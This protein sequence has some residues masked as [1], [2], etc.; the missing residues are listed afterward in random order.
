MTVI[1]FDKL[2]GVQRA[3]MCLADPDAPDCPVVAVND[4]FVDLTGYRREDIL[5]RNCRFL[6]GPG[7][8]PEAVAVLGAAVRAREAVSICITNYRANGE[9]FDNFLCITTLQSSLDKTFFLGCQCEILER[10]WA[11]DIEKQ[12]AMLADITDGVG[13]DPV[14]QSRVAQ[15]QI[16]ARSLAAVARSYFA[17]KASERLMPRGGRHSQQH[18][19]GG[20]V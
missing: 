13:V 3:P 9:P 15:F 18:G 10:Q 20:G 2:F 6:Q 1:A 7:T 11:S 17:I 12:A 5:G 4:A 8:R 19:G 16:E 14:G